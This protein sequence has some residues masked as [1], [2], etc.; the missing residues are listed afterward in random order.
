MACG[1]VCFVSAVWVCASLVLVTLVVVCVYY[2]VG[3]LCLFVVVMEM[4]AW[5]GLM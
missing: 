2:L 5:F 3:A 4:G 1:V